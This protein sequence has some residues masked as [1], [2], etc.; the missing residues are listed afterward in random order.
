MSDTRVKI[1]GRQMTIDERNEYKEALRASGAYGKLESGDLSK[2]TDGLLS[3]LKGLMP[4]LMCSQRCQID[5][6]KEQ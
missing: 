5:E 3:K 4:N 1:I 6:R 2:A